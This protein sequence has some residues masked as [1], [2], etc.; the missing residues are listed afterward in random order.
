M[1]EIPQVKRGESI[2]R[3][4]RKTAELLVL[5]AKYHVTKIDLEI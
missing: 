1:W 3:C 2:M 5:I 4:R